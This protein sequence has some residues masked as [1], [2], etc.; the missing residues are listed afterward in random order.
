MKAAV[1]LLAALPAVLPA[2]QTVA[3]T[4]ER[5][6]EP[7]G[8]NSGNY[9]IVQ[10][11]EL[12][13]RFVS[14]GGNSGKYRSDVNFGNGPRLL[15]SRLSVRSRDGH[16]GPFD[17]LSL[18]TQGLGN[19]PYQSASMRLAKTRLYRYDALW[20][21]SAYYNPAL[22]ISAGQHA[23][24]TVRR[25]QDHDFTLL[26]QSKVRFFAG[27]TRVNQEGPALTTTNLFDG[28]RGDE[29][30][31]FANLRRRQNEFR[32]GNELVLFGMK[33]NW[34]QGWELY[35]ENS[36]LSLAVPSAGANATDR[37]T[38]SA[39]SQRDPIEGMTPSFRLSL[40]RERGRRWAANGRFTHS[41]GRR[42]FAFDELATGAD[43]FAGA[44]NRQILVS[45]NARRPVTTGAVTLTFFPHDNLT[46]VNHSAFHSTRMEGDSTYRE[47]ENSSLN[48]A[49]VHF[50]YL[51]IRMFSN[52]TDG[53]LQWKPWLALRGGFH[54][55]TRRIRSAEQVEIDGFPAGRRGEQ[56]NRLSAGS[57]GFRLR[58]AKPLTLALDGEMGRQ[59]HPFYPTSE[60]N[61][62][63]FSARLQYRGGPLQFSAT[64]RSYANFNSL[65]FFAHSDRSRNYTAGASWNPRD[66]F[67]LDAG[68]SKLHA[69][70]STGIAYFLSPALIQADRS[71]FLTNLH[72]GHLGVHVS[73]RERVDLYAGLSLSRDAGGGP[74]R[75]ATALPALA[76]LQVFPM[77]Y[78]A[79][80]ARISVKLH[81]QLRWNAGYQYY[82]YR[83]DLL[84][85]QNYRAHTGYTS[86]LW[87]F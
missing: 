87:T 12:G 3:P 47:L 84:P 51:G 45:G 31:L 11:W 40:F 10:D 27:F 2:Q 28:A 5:T 7:R 37:T 30:P 79:P 55:S 26:P 56:Q 23:M 24:D 54:Y 1:L 36:P 22:A 33:L 77:A 35:R 46:L 63:A 76:A 4:P 61:Y 57:A 52:S 17:E 39:Y 67:S 75:P 50:Q 60:K 15:S 72:T 8:S 19:D 13:Y 14:S 69:Y 18:F 83:E 16:G 25:L 53:V 65:S 74:G 58:P 62:H 80:L 70:T 78:D 49:T 9:N 68:Y 86:V 34:M 82:R 71:V 29:F 59:D 85:L 38:L 42:D 81:T 41:A 20:R 43:R 66:W 64:A 6:G 48:L 21:S 32:F 44:R 73:L